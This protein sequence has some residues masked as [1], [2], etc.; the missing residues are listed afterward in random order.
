MANEEQLT[1]NH[2][3]ELLQALKDLEYRRGFVEAHAKDTI[4]FQLRQLR[5]AEGWEQRDVAERLG[6]PS[7]QPMISRYENPDYG[8][9]SISTLLELASVFDVA[10]VVRFAPYS[11]LLEW[12]WSS[13]ANTLCPASFEKDKRIVKIGVEI[14]TEQECA[15]RA[16][17]RLF[18]AG[19]VIEYLNHGEQ[20]N[21][22]VQPGSNL[23]SFLN[24]KGTV[25]LV[26]AA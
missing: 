8:R 11:E 20:T 14:R 13:N 26:G 17:A 6:N 23:G 10:L 19:P 7:L 9:Y 21:Q 22:V 18:P 4:A 2:K 25:R 1:L 16:Q 3:A 12:D 5:K 15:A 24:A